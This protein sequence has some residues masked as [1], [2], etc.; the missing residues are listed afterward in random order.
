MATRVNQ[1][2]YNKKFNKELGD[3]ALLRDSNPAFALALALTIFSIAGI[4]PLIGFFA[5]IGIFLSVLYA[6]YYFVA[7]LAILCSVV[8]TFYYLRIIKI[9]Y[10][11]NTLV[12]KLYY[13]TVNSKTFLFSIFIFFLIVCFISPTFLSLL[14][15][16]VIV[17]SY[18]G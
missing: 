9:L 5:K 1:K 7:L 3:L 18:I 14:T 17:C 12:G 13:P 16:K 2:D 10:F 8:S 11:E 15:H 6:Q 4:P